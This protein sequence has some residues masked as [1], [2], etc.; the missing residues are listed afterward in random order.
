MEEN[1]KEMKSAMGPGKNI[2]IVS[3]GNCVTCDPSTCSAA[4]GPCNKIMIFEFSENITVKDGRISSRK[5]A[6][7]CHMWSVQS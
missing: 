3:V 5:S 4:N 6:S 1:I 7:S 2:A